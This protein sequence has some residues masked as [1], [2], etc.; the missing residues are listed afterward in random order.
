VRPPTVD[1]LRNITDRA[2]RGPLHPDE[3]ARLRQGIDRLAARRTIRTGA[4][5]WANR[6]HALRRRLAEL[7]YPV[8]HGDIAACAECSGWN[9]RRCTGLIAQWPCPTLTT[10][11]E[12][13]PRK[14]AE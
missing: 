10:V 2:Y 12:S 8:Q 14:G 3:I 4:A 1:Q 5:S 7:H 13:L 6:L 9:G 11:D